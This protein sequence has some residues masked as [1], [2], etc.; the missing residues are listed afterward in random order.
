M[1][2]YMVATAEPSGFLQKFRAHLAFSARAHLGPVAIVLAFAAAGWVAGAQ[3]GL[4]IL[5]A[6][7]LY[8]PT[9]VYVV[10]LAIALILALRGARIILVERPK[11]PLTMLLRE[12]RDRYATAEVIAFALPVLLFMPVFAGTFTLFKSL[13]SQ[14]NPFAWD[15]TFARWDSILHFGYAPWELL[16][17]LLGHPAITWSVNWGYN[18]WFFVLALVW[19]WQA[20][21]LRD[22]HGRLQFFY[23]LLLSW[24]LLGCIGAI[25]FASAGP[26]YYGLVVDGNDP[27]APL[28]AYLHDADTV[29]GVWALSAQDT[30]WRV[31]N[32]EELRL[33]GGISAMPSMHVA[34]AFLFFLVARRASRI[35]GAVLFAYF[36]LILIGSVHLAWHYAIDG[37]FAVLA[38]LAIWW[39]SGRLAALTYPTTRR[40]A[41]APA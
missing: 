1:N 13:V 5:R 39:L 7:W 15:E 11:R 9:Y 27:F 21:S 26:C 18:A 20:F 32:A 2:E 37:Y 41:P 28:M 31:L 30:L 3:Y 4:S 17:P 35:L 8:I 16:Q 29:Y 6:V 23:T 34:M 24:I 40:A 38:T 14:I 36:L 25:V 22:K 12:I 10:P 19:L 33:G